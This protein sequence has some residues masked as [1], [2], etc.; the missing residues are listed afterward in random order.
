MALVENSS[1]QSNGMPSAPLRALKANVDLDAT[2]PAGGYDLSAIFPG[3]V[4]VHGPWIPSYDGAALYWL[5]LVD[6]GGTPKLMV[7]DTANGAPG[8]E[9]ATADQSGH[10][11]LDVYGFGE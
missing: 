7:H 6:D 11:G 4:V 2:Y 9:T 1:S 10:T 5:R 3:T 8:A